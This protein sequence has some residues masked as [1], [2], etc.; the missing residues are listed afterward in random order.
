MPSRRPA[1]LYSRFKTVTFD[2]NREHHHA[3]YKF[4]Q[5]KRLKRIKQVLLWASGLGFIILKRA[6][7]N[8][9]FQ[10]LWSCHVS[11]RH[12]QHF[13]KIENDY[14][15]SIVEIGDTLNQFAFVMVS[16][17]CV[18]IVIA[19]LCPAEDK[20][21]LSLEQWRREA[22]KNYQQL[23]RE[24]RLYETAQDILKENQKLR[25]Q[26]APINNHLIKLQERLVRVRLE[27]T[28]LESVQSGKTVKKRSRPEAD[29]FETAPSPPKTPARTIRAKRRLPKRRRNIPKF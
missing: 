16:A 23:K 8:E 29:L 25:D 19:L 12:N 24:T 17:Y 5:F 28:A 9:T 4:D 21:E 10:F 3:N 7:V 13:N 22:E 27:I 26:F 6:E 15:F 14:K 1:A 2:P 18:Y 20:D 11:A